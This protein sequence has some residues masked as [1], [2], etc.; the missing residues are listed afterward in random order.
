M[1]WKKCTYT[2]CVCEIHL[3]NANFKNGSDC[4]EA[5]EKLIWIPYFF[6]NFTFLPQKNDFIIYVLIKIDSGFSRAFS[7]LIINR[8]L[9]F[10]VCG[11][12]SILFQFVGCFSEHVLL[13]VFFV[14][15]CFCSNF[16][17]PRFLF[18]SRPLFCFRKLNFSYTESDH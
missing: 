7:L 14:Y 12:I 17:R 10:F 11:S 16:F 9:P 18:P 13:R 6:L 5:T 1:V 2:W 15:F 8:V 3:F 4:I